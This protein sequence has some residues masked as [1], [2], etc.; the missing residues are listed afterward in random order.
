MF[1]SPNQKL[2][3]TLAYLRV[4]NNIYQSIIIEIFT[5]KRISEAYG[6]SRIIH[7]NN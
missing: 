5:V 1:S 3:L 4:I 6:S 2:R 7:R